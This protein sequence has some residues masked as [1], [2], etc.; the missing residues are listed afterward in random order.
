MCSVGSYG[1]QSKLELIYPDVVYDTTVG[2]YTA[3]GDGLVGGQ[4]KAAILPKVDFDTDASVSPSAK[5][6]DMFEDRPRRNSRTYGVE[7][8]EGLDINNTAAMLRYLILQTMPLERRP[9]KA[10][11]CR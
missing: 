8:P 4:C 3:I 1:E 10:S 7:Y 6:A 2:G 5:T 11:R 9:L